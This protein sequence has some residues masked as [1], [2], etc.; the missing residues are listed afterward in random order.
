MTSRVVAENDEHQLA[1]DVD[2]EPRDRSAR[3]A[4][5]LSDALSADTT[6]DPT[7]ESRA[8]PSRLWKAST[9]DAVAAPK[10][11]SAGPGR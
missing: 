6:P 4:G 11:P 3:R 9:A 5:S 2:V 1:G 10:L 7:T 8:N